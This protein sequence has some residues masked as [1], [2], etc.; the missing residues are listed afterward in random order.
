MRDK[1]CCLSNLNETNDIMCNT[2][3]SLST[4]WVDEYENNAN[5]IP[6]PSQST[7][8]NPALHLWETLH[9]R[10]YIYILAYPCVMQIH[11]QGKT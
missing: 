11:F 10:N 8:L 1:R 9:S 3:K 2:P 7:D 4:E 6:W 5:R